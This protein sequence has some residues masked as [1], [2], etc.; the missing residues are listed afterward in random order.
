[1]STT[2]DNLKEAFAGESQANQSYLAFA[3]KADNENLPTITRLFRAAAAA[4]TVHAQNHAAA[5]EMVGPTLDNLKT[6]AAGEKAE[7]KEMYP[8]FIEQAEKEGNGQAR[9]TF[10][11]ANQVEQIHH[12][13]YSEGIKT[14]E[15]G[16]DLPDTKIFV[17]RGCG[18]TV[19]GQAPEK[20]P[21]CGAP[22][23]WF[24]HIE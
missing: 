20:C 23:S 7:F 5:M 12:G 15:K 14:L 1:M 4:E 18:N 9:Q 19:E 22:P 24:M 21:I 10:D 3:K 8:A 6:A 2:I 17:C 13:L 11:H 16:E